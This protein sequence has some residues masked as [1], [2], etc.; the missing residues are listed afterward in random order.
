MKYI[1][2]CIIGG[3]LFI[4]AAGCDSIPSGNTSDSAVLSSLTISPNNIQFGPN[5]SIGDTTVTIDLSV[6]T[7][8]AP[9][10]ELLYT[11][12]DD[13]TFRTE[14]SLQ[15]VSDNLFS[16]SSNLM[17]NSATSSNFTI[18]VYESQSSSGQRLQGQLRITGR[19]VSPP[20]ILEVDNPEE[21]T[22]PESG[23]RRIDF[24]ARVTHPDGQELISRVNFFLIDQTGSQLGNDFQMYD[25]GFFNEIE[26]FI[27]ETANDSLY[28][29]AFFIN[30]NNNPDEITV[31]YFAIGNDGQSSDTLQTQLS[32]VE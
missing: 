1:L 4:M 28:S 25:D 17:V 26:G 16:V 9:A 32:I 2:I 29:R 27:D 12:E 24:F 15:A 21:V 3:S 30:P 19:T 18:Y 7:T 6:S 14:G 20:V 23:N 11:I 22:I 8:A 31:N 5:A 10:N 13:G